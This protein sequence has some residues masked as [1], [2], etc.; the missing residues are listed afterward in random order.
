MM[1]VGVGC[2]L[3]IF[4]VMMTR[5]LWLLVA[6]A[7]KF[8]LNYAYVKYVQVKNTLLCVCFITCVSSLQCMFLCCHNF[9]SVI[10]NL[11]VCSI[12]ANYHV[13]ASS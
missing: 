4:C 2:C 12:L 7:V 13:S 8:V 11:L 3:A 5:R 6:C 10:N 1:F 9:T